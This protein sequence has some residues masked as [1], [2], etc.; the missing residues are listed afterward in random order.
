[1]TNSSHINFSIIG[2]GHIAQRHAGHLK[3][4][5]NAALVA[6]YDLDSSL[7]RSFAE[8]F[9]I[10][11]CE[12]LEAVLNTNS[13][14]IIIATPNA[15]HCDIARKCVKA[16]KHV[17]IEKPMDIDSSKA[18]SLIDLARSLDQQVFVVKQNRYNPPIARLKNLLEQN[19]LGKIHNISLHCYWNRNADY[20]Q[21]S[22]WRGTRS[23]DGGTL[24][25]QFSHFID[26]I[27]YLFGEVEAVN[28]FL[29]KCRDEDYLEF[30]D[31]ANF[32][33]V[34]KNGATGSLS[35]ST[36]AFDHN[37]EGSLTLL[38]DRCTLKIGGKYLNSL[39]YVAGMEEDFA[40]LEHSRPANDYGHYEGSMSNHDKVLK[41]V[42]ASLNG[43]QEI[44]TTGEDG[45]AVVQ[46]IEQFYQNA[47]ELR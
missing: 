1:M 3:E 6:C 13:D 20:Y 46:L 42:I 22:A 26:I 9:S 8:R 37:M 43:Q 34:M 4:I 27:Y 38:S 12:N 36:T 19:K 29:N 5:E 30:E 2:C 39:E 17:L 44:M 47:V 21:Q 45:L 25:T 23:L 28:G 11:A 7:N 24:F 41:N 32:S 31:N 14:V 33:F 40:D 35:Y 18:K 10:D 16:G 15:T